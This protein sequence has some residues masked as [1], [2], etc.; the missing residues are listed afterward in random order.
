MRTE[1]ELRRL[2][3]AAEKI[4]AIAEKVASEDADDE[5]EVMLN[6]ILAACDE[7]EHLAKPKG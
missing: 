2:A 6:N 4:R 5:L 7:I 1:K 3:K